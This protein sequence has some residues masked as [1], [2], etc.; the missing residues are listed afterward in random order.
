MLKLILGLFIFSFTNL[1][2]AQKSASTEF[3]SQDLKE[4]AIQTYAGSSYYSSL[5]SPFC[6][7]GYDIS[8]DQLHAIVIDQIGIDVLPINYNVLVSREMVCQGMTFT[9]LALVQV[10]FGHLANGD[11]G[12]TG[13]VNTIKILDN[14][15]L[16]K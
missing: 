12:Y 14:N 10:K 3:F 16:L 13:Y 15:N 1:S 5:V 2:M 11:L 8:D 6:V 7:P 4:A 9:N